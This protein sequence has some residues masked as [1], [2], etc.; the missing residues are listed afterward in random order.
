MRRGRGRAAVGGLFVA[1]LIGCVGPLGT[2]DAAPLPAVDRDPAALAKAVA[3]MLTARAEAFRRH[4]TT[5]FMVTVDTRDTAFAQRQRAL[6]ENAKAVP[7]ASY[8]LV[9][10]VEDVGDLSRPADL[11]RFGADTVV[12]DVRETLAIDGGYDAGSPAVEE[13]FLTLSRNGDGRWRVAA[14]DGA[15]DMGLQS[16]RHPWD[17]APISVRRS[18][19][20]L[21]LYPPN[22]SGDAPKVLD[23]AEAALRVVSPKWTPAWNRKVIIELPKDVETLGKRILATFPLD[24]FVAFA[25]SSVTVE[26]LDLEFTGRRVLINPANFL[27]SSAANRR[28]ILA[29]ELVHV[30]TRES[31][32]AYLTAWVEEGVAQAIGEEESAVGLEPSRLAVR[33]GQFRGRFPEDYEF[34]VGGGQRIFRS[35]AEAY[36]ISREIEKIAGRAGLVRF[37]VEAGERGTLGPGTSRH[38]LDLATRRALGIS[39]DELERRWAADVRAGRLS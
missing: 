20:F 4:D 33:R 32:G 6:V 23:E 21:A 22:R 2:A 19:N 25:A 15:D 18:A 31:A 37:Y 17:Y 11:R 14:D 13:M 24:N 1:G 28:Q 3:P 7:F 26:G 38:R 10:R 5:A 30:A 9:P 34:L 35:Y 29:H 16:A 12:M 36:L 27:G 39:L 8:A